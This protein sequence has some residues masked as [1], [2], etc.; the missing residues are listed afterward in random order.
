MDFGKRQSRR[1]RHRISRFH[2]RKKSTLALFTV[3][4]IHTIDDFPLCFP[5]RDS[6]RLVSRD[7]AVQS[8]KI[9]LIVPARLIRGP[10]RSGGRPP[11]TS[12]PRL[13]LLQKREY[14][15]LDL[16]RIPRHCVHIHSRAVSAS[17]DDHLLQNHLP[18]TLLGARDAPV[19][20]PCG[21]IANLERKPRIHRY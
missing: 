6:S 18:G 1:A 12:S 8:L 7:R 10:I 21:C 9:D 4:A 20:V 3:S 14:V 5:R 17:A 13:A 19:I 16:R 15:I 11:C 2:Y